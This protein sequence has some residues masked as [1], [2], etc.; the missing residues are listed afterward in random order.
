[1]NRKLYIYETNCHGEGNVIYEGQVHYYSYDGVS[2]D[3]KAA[4]QALI[5]IGFINPDDVVFIDGDEIY[6]YLKEE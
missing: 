6:D 4:V 1:M 3:V 2:G 5:E